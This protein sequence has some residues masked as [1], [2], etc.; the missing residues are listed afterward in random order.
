MV[1]S[2]SSGGNC[3]GACQVGR[4]PHPVGFTFPNIICGRLICRRVKERQINTE[5]TIW[6]FLI[7]NGDIAY[8]R[9]IPRQQQLPGVKEK[10]RLSGWGVCESGDL[11]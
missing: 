10:T 9:K 7:I 1:I 11:E 8:Q 2:Q 4:A 5:F 6:V 3:A